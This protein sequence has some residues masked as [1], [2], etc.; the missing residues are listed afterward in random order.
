MNKKRV[1]ILTFD[2]EDWFHTFNKR[3]YKKAEKWKI[4]PARLEKNTE[5]ICTFLSENQLKATFF[6]L[7][8]EA[9]RYPKLVKKLA[10]EGHEIAAHSFYHK[11]TYD[12]SRKA[13]R[14][15]TEKVIKTL[16]DLTG[17]KVKTYRAPGMTINENT[18][19]ALDILH[20]L[21]IQN[22]SSVVAIKKSKFPSAPFLF[23]HNGIKTKEFP[24]PTVSVFGRKFNYSSSG[25]F[26][27]VPFSWIKRKMNKTDYMLFYFH[28]RDFD[29]EMPRH[30]PND[31]ILKIRYGI[32][33]NHSLSKLEKLTN[34]FHFINMEE[35]EGQINWEKAPIVIV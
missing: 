20:E 15:D 21:G 16:E 6:W 4:L 24:V 7:G 32:G 27:I 10:A 1:Y 25:Y 26:R 18:L 22:D 28:P 13:F 31:P 35:A 33:V 3:F 14:K 5:K 29:S 23:L 8:W 17:K 2:I 9:E 11:K 30:V 34:T 12:V 19:W